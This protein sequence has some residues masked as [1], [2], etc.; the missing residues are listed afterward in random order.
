MLPFAPESLESL[1]A[2]YPAAVERAI[3]LAGALGDPGDFP[4]LNRRH[5]FD[6][7]DGLR[8][9]VSLDDHGPRGGVELHASASAAPKSPLRRSIAA[10]FV[11]AERFLERARS[12]FHALSGW[13]G[14]MP[15]GAIGA[16]GVPHWFL[17][18]TPERRNRKARP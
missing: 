12:A 8:L 3:D 7:D 18:A 4:G 6:F 13:D 11:D 17:D 2:R 10:G 14:P 9:I 5:V 16:G 15:V 1:K